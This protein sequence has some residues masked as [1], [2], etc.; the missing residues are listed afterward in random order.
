MREHDL[1]SSSSAA[2]EGLEGIRY[3][4]HGGSTKEK[5]DA[6]LEAFQYGL[7]GIDLVIQALG[8]D[9]REVR[10][11][12]LL[13]LSYSS[14]ANAEQAILNYLPFAKMQCLY[15]LTEFNLDCYNPEQH[16][17]YYF[18]IADYNNT[19]ICY[20][21]LFYKQSFV[22][23]WHLETGQS[24]KDF[25][26]AMAHEF[27]LG[28][29]SKV[30]IISFQDFLWPLDTETQEP[31][32]T[33]PDYL[34]RTVQAHPHCLAICPT[35][36][37]LVA[38]GYTQGRTGKLD[39]WDYETY[40][41]RLHH[42][43]QDVAL[44]PYDNS[45]NQSKLNLWLTTPLLFTPDG[46]FLVARFKQR[47]QNRLQLWNTETGELTQ[48]LDNLPALTVN[49][50]A[51]RL[52]GQILACGIRENKVCVWELI[53][54][55]ILYTSSGVAPCLISSDGRVFICCTDNYEIV[56]WDLAMNRKLC[57]L[58]SHTAPIGY[59]AM[60]SNCEFIASYSIDR[61]IKVWAV[62]ESLR[63]L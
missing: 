62:P 19:L 45:W 51:N 52:D 47:L 10:Q 36:Q 12:A 29:S 28:K 53:S 46:K 33:Y 40:T 57:T 11:S 31:I 5:V 32:G 6:L 24:N 56:V 37:P 15:T 18:A 23:I 50:L 22:N 41:R 63:Y 38:T 8:D 35:K 4:L 48:T 16:H 39:I 27:C 2:L 34:M 17:P 25:D 55:R 44:I 7:K 42:Q 59:V 13:L 54:D 20:W 49:S 26:L 1:V 30:C 3:R 9:V 58:Q 60:S 43:F 61:K 21:D 14:E